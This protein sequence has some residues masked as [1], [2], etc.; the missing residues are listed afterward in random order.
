MQSQGSRPNGHISRTPI[1]KAE[2]K[3][4]KRGWK[5][6][7][8]QR[9]KNFAEATKSPQCGCQSKSSNGHATGEGDHQAST[10]YK[11]QVRS[12]D[13]GRQSTPGKTANGQS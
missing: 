13:Q 12:A 10:L 2:G 6:G 9:M 1:P 8:S 4:Q 7:K 11:R 5:D 3:V